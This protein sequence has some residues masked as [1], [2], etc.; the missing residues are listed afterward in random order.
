MAEAGGVWAVLLLA[1][2]ATYLSRG[3]GVLFAERI[4]PE[5][6]TFRWVGCVA[7][8]MLAGLVARM[9]LMPIGPLAQVD[10]ATRSSA[11]VAAAAIYLL[12]RRNLLAGLAA[13]MGV[14]FL[15]IRGL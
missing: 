13:G 1:C 4:D 14:L 2:L 5:G 11:A 15:M 10:L 3:L 8:A 7:Y 12:S 6:P 9:I